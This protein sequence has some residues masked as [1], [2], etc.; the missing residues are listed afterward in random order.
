[1]AMYYNMQFGGGIEVTGSYSPY[2]TQ[3][4]LYPFNI[5]VGY[6]TSSGPGGDPNSQPNHDVPSPDPSSNKTEDGLLVDVGCWLYRHLQGSVTLNA[7]DGPGV[8]GAIS[9]S[10]EGVTGSLGGGV[11]IGLNLVGSATANFGNFKGW[12]NQLSGGLAFL[13]GARGAFGLSENGLGGDF[14]WGMG[15]GA[16]ITFTVGYSG[17][18]LYTFSEPP[19]GL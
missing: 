1:M 18:P 3:G 2:D 8:T 16:G 19:C 14:G 7:G 6:G 9:V 13:G 4:G 10:R 11:G 12:N 5:M 17:I 15:G